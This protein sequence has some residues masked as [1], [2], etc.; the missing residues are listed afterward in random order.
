MDIGCPVQF[1]RF[2]SRDVFRILNIYHNPT[3]I[4]VLRDS[5]IHGY[6]G[7]R[8]VAAGREQQHNAK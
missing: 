6:R 3:A 8:L 2:P 5:A 4:A 1:A 7:Y